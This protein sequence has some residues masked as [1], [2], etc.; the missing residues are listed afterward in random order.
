MRKI[1]LF[2]VYCLLTT[3]YGC[4]LMEKA[5]MN[6]I[7]PNPEIKRQE[8]ETRRYETVSANIN[9]ADTPE[10]VKAQERTFYMASKQSHPSLWSSMVSGLYTEEGRRL[11]GVGVAFLASMGVMIWKVGQTVVLG[12]ALDSTIL[13]I[14]EYR[15]SKPDKGVDLKAVLSARHRGLP[16]DMAKRVSKVLKEI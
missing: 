2:T 8:Q 4:G 6:A 11:A 10:K 3:C 5:L 1:F 7:S 9:Q 12:K 13:G 15:N 14:Q 16:F